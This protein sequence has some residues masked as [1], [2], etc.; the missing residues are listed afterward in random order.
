MDLR[1]NQGRRPFPRRGSGT[2]WVC[3][4]FLQDRR[5][6]CLPG[7]TVCPTRSPPQDTNHSTCRGECSWSGPL[8]TPAGRC[9]LGPLANGPGPNQPYCL[10]SGG[11]DTDTGGASQPLRSGTSPASFAGS[12]LPSPPP[13][14][15]VLVPA[16]LLP[17][18]G[19]SP[20]P[21]PLAVLPGSCRVPSAPAV[22]PCSGALVSFFFFTPRHSSLP[23]A[24][25]SVPCPPPTSPRCLLAV[26][27]PFVGGWRKRGWGGG[28]LPR[29]LSSGVSTSRARC[30]HE[31]RHW[32]LC[33]WGGG[34]LAVWLP[35]SSYLSC[36]RTPGGPPVGACTARAP[37]G[38]GRVV[39]PA[40]SLR[41]LPTLPRCPRGGV[42][43]PLP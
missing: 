33:R 39:R 10:R 8:A 2:L 32:P 30:R 41:C 43:V 11:A 13:F 5:V 40:P 18:P 29:C 15:A 14:T 9:H 35:L 20:F 21:A 23:P 36:G 1:R 31:A 12:C 26:L 37:F 16:S 3:G 24:F 25:R 38:H 28:R 6:S 17:S 27:A 7:W 4:E 19:A 42:R 22:C 34:G